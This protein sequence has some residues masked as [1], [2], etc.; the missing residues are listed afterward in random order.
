[1]EKKKEFI[2]IK[3]CYQNN[4]KNIDINIPLGEFIVFTGVSGAGKS[5]LV[6]D[7]IYA[8]SQR[9]FFLSLSTFARQFF[10][11][12]PPP[13][14]EEIEGL[15]PSIA[16]LR[17]GVVK[18]PRST[19]A[20][21]TEI[22]D[23]LRVLYSKISELYCPECGRK[24]IKYDEET[25]KKFIIKKYKNKK[26]MIG[27]ITEKEL[28]DIYKGG[29]VYALVD[30]EKETVFKAKEGVKHII[31]DTLIVN[32]DERVFEDIKTGFNWSDNIFVKDE[33]GIA[34]FSNRY[35]CPYC[36]L[37]FN[38]PVPELF[39]FNSSRGACPKCKGFGDIITVD[40]KKVIPDESL[41]I[42]EG[43]IEVFKTPK[44]KEL[45]NDLL[46]FCKRKGIKTDIPVKKLSESE[47]RLLM[48]GEGGYYGIKGFFEWLE[49]KKYKTHVRVFLSRYRKY[50]KCPV[51]YGG[52]LNREALS[53]KIEGKNIAELNKMEI[54][55][56]FEFIKK[57]DKIY[58]NN[59]AVKI[60]IQEIKERVAYLI[61]VGLGYLSLNRKTFTLS[62]GEA[63]R[64][65]LTSVLGS[66]L[67]DT[68]ILIDEPSKGLHLKDFN[69]LVKTIEKINNSGNTIIMIE[70]LEKVLKTA[71]RIVEIGP[72]AGESG[73][74]IIFSG[75][76]NEYKKTKTYK[77]TQKLIKKSEINRKNGKIDA[78]MI[79]KKAEK[80]NLKKINIKIP[81]NK[82]TCITGVSGAGKSTLLYEILYKGVKGEEKNFENMI[83]VEKFNKENVIYIDDSPPSKSS[84]AIVG[85]YLKLL[86]SIRKLFSELPESKRRGFTSSHFSYN[87]KEGQCPDCKGEGY[88][89]V[90]MQFLS[91]IKLVCDS[92]GG[93]RFND[94]VLKIKFGNLNIYD[95]F[96]LSLNE[97]EEIFRKE[98]PVLADKISI[99]NKMGI[100]YLKLGQTL[101][102]L[103]GGESQRVKLAK[104]MLY[105]N[106]EDKLFL[107]DEPT[108]GLHPLD[109]SKI[110]GTLRDFMD[111]GAT[112]VVVE[113]NPLF[114]INSDY[115]I[116]LGP[117]GGDRG[118]KIVFQGMLSEFLLSNKS[119]TA[120]TLRDY[121][122]L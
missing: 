28:K 85:T 121:Y 90:E 98:I 82:I 32:D 30:G 43:A 25:L 103:S 80:Y 48:D 2:K 46:Q 23:F 60:I 58:K 13:D 51:C 11:R 87:R 47:K 72:G 19:V 40:E 61:D 29:F 14:V 115:I 112:M 86:D 34:L 15:Q 8:E 76:F 65:S 66:T 109:I 45:Y 59:K 53:Y 49:R 104:H 31:I 108:T 75:G 99:I 101:S 63:Q 36:S 107:I 57:I 73:G 41:S 54:N 52:R 69:T 35:Y 95:I 18:N 122:S 111:L 27:F 12:I 113:H 106:V 56:F 33:S 91:D 1:M 88:I 16:I 6:F 68:M 10:E 114:I 38:E 117:E 79:I 20:T 74:E 97:V 100:G 83:G 119:I 89:K 21:I 9:R 118:G 37:N 62:R 50:S 5:S 22:Y 110:V 116:D 102:T 17:K 78:Y 64:I 26:I 7:T 77:N 55:N 92:C 105:N 94:E 70:H 81:H 39:S 44:A 42:E 84:R 96:E 93:K 24:I 4:L 71:D 67:T 3:N 120:I